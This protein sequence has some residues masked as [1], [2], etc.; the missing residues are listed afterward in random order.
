MPSVSANTALLIEQWLG[1]ALTSIVRAEAMV[2]SQIA[3]VVER[4]G[5]ER[6]ED[7]TLRARTFSFQFTRTE[8]NQATEELE[9]RTV[10]ATVPLLTIIRL[11]AVAVDEAT[12]DMSL[13]VVAQERP[14]NGPLPP[15]EDRLGDLRRLADIGRPPGLFAIPARRPVRPPPGQ[16]TTESATQDA[17]IHVTVR[18]RRLEQ[19][20]GLDRLESVLDSAFAERVEPPPG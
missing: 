20:L 15:P 11:P 14:G 2:A 9:E 13:R 10:T 17:S 12:I 7:G 8:L 1:G 5:F 16:P 18:L 19:P 3:D 4:V 6:G